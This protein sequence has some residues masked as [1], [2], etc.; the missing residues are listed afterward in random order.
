M[1]SSGDLP[2]P[3]I[4]PAFP[5]APALQVDSLLL[6]HQGSPMLRGISLK[7]LQQVSQDPQVLIFNFIYFSFLFILIRG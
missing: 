1:P 5:V 2:N 6:S 3:G 4:E 7:Y